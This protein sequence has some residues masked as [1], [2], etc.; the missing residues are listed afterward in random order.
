M[1]TREYVVSWLI[2]LV[3]AMLLTFIIVNLGQ[4]K[5]TIRYDCSI[6]EISPD[7][8]VAVKEACRKRSNK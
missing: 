3:S 6:A 5:R 8:P 4:D 1:T 7:Y 2:L